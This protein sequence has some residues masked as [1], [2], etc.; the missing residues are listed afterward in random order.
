[1]KNFNVIYKMIDDLK[2]E[3]S[4]QLPDIDVEEILGI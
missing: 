1:M 2:E 3:I 4:S